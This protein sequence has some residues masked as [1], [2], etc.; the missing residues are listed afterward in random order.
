MT[1]EN[2]DLALGTDRDISVESDDL[3]LVAGVD[4][5]AQR[6]IV[7]LRMFLGEWFLTP[8]DGMPWY[9]SVLI[10]SPKSNVIEA[11]FRQH[12]LADGDIESIRSL[13]L[14]ID[15]R[16]RKLTADFEAVSGEGTVSVKDIFP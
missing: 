11:M 10:N 13:A 8:N 4:L 1:D 15:K 3:K 5:I 6:L 9:Q 16:T 2:L 7:G 14:T 12:I